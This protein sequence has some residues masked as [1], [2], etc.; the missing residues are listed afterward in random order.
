[1]RLVPSAALALALALPGLSTR[2]AGADDRTFAIRAGR[3]Y[4]MAK[5][6]GWVVDQCVIVVENGRFKAVGRDAEIPPF[7]RVIDMPDAVILPGLVSADSWLAGEHLGEESVGPQYRAIDA[8]DPHQDYAR[9]LAGGVTTLYVNPGRHRLVS[10]RAGVVRLGARPGDAILAAETDL[11]INLGEAAFD[12]PVKQHWLV[13]PSSFLDIEP[14]TVQRPTS[15]LGQLL[16]LNQSF[17]AAQRYAEARENRRAVR[18]GEAPAFD[19]VHEALADVQRKKS[20]LRINADRAVDIEQG[21]TFARGRRHA[22]VLA[23]AVESDLLAGQI[24]AAQAPIVYRIDVAV[25]R[26]A[27]DLGLDADALET[28]RA[29]PP[30]LHAVPMAIVGPP[31]APHGE[32]MYYATLAVARGLPPRKAL[33]GITSAAAGI[34]GVG[35]RAGSIQPGRSADFVVLNS[36]PLSANT[37]VRRVYVDGRVAFDAERVATDSVVIRAGRIWTGESW[38]ENGEVSIEKGRVVSAGPT[39]PV[40]PFARVIDAGRD[41]VVTPGFIDARGHLGLSGDRTPA[42]SELTP[43]DALYHADVDFD[44]VARSGVTTVLLSAYRPGGK[45]AR[46]SAI[47]T[48]GDRPDALVVKRTAGLVVSVRG[49]EPSA[50]AGTLRGTLGA[51]KKYDDEWKKYEK[52]LAEWLAKPKA[53]QQEKKPE[54]RKV[55]EVVEEKKVVDPVTGTWRGTVSGAPLPE[56]QEFIAKMKLDG[57]QVE[58]SLES[59]IG[60]D[61]TVAIRGTFRDKHLS[62]EVDVDIP[63]GKPRIEADIDREDHFTGTLSVAQFVFELEANRTEKDVPQIKI[64]RTRKKKADDGRPAAPKRDESLEPYRDLFAGRIAL[65]VDVDSARIIEAVLPVFEQEHKVP[66]VLLNAEES[67]E[68]ANRLAAAGTGVILPTQTVRKVN[69]VDFVQ[70]AVLGRAGVPIAFQSDAEDAARQL[71]I[72]AGY[73]VRMGLDATTALKALTGDAARL[74]KCDSDVGFLKKGCRGDVLIFDGPPLEPGT[75]LKR[76]LIDGRE[77][78]TR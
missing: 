12:P 31:G 63:I 69:R 68:V 71:P 42:G 18:K 20:T 74:M 58:G 37:H 14:A 1:M 54:P 28:D 70:S 23:G 45:G 75:R 27:A 59:I 15:R 43:A 26:N 6:D 61:E 4:T 65:V 35:D 21:M 48:A 22:Y 60:G 52:D 30:A 44:R 73:D 77:V 72:R 62:L 24:A 9:V 33:E 32:L 57:E 41:A 46:V 50:A 5:G 49:Q 2:S 11:V 16:Q 47:H 13:P 64:T 10:G 19:A 67:D 17:D 29:I 39:A 3:V 53:E 25:N 38:I 55:E 56:P 76:V 34:L 8:F 7:A 51:G 78:S 36:E 40:P 66:F